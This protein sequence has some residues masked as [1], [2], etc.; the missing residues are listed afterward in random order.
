MAKRMKIRTSRDGCTSWRCNASGLPHSI[1]ASPSA[2]RRAIAVALAA[3]GI[4]GCGDTALLSVTDGTGPAPT[5][6]A[7]AVTLIPTVNV[8]KAT[9]W[10][11]DRKP[12]TAPGTTVGRF[13]EALE[14]PRWLYV[15][16][17]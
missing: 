10:P 3:I 17:N 11:A 4:A 12:A 13:A 2:F 7:P 9:G 8:A 15:L 6:P 16:P 5:L 14:H 1:A